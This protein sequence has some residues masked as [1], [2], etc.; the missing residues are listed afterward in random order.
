MS[1]VTRGKLIEQI[2]R[3]L[4]GGNIPNDFPISKEEVE[5]FILQR[6]A[7]LLRIQ[8][9]EGIKYDN[10]RAV[11]PHFTATFSSDVKIDKDRGHIY[12]LL[13]DATF[14]DLMGGRGIQRVQPKGAKWGNDL[15]PLSVGSS[16]LLAN[17]PAGSLEGNCGYYVEND[18]IVIFNPV[19]QTVPKTVFITLVTGETGELDPAIADVVRDSAIEFFS[20]RI[21]RDMLNDEN[22]DILDESQK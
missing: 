3:R 22:S 17:I 8:L 18:R 2:R 11:N 9:I 16:P 7:Y 21:P 20:P 19:N 5:I 6:V 14:I 15:K 12:A 10:N 13:P 1:K 4:A